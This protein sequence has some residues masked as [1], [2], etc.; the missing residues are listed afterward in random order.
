MNDLFPLILYTLGSFCLIMLGVVLF[1]L[2]ETLTSVNDLIKDVNKKTKQ[3]DGVFE[4]V[5]KSSSV[6]NGFSEKA[7][8]YIL[9]LINR[10]K[11]E[12]EENE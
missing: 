8:N 5:D 4:I 3:L 7:I 6:V 1:K 11:K 9:G 10:K 2:A 12:S